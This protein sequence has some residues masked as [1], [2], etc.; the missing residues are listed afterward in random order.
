[1]HI[2]EDIKDHFYKELTPEQ[3]KLAHADEW[4]FDSPN[5]LDFDVMVEIL[6]DLKQ[7]YRIP[8]H[9]LLISPAN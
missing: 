7:G 5:A 6:R 3:N 1:V 4:D 9:L 8:I 2:E